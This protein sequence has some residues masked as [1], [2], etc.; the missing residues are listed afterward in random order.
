ME[1]EINKVVW[2]F[3][4]EESQQI[5]NIKGSIITSLRKW[6]LEDAYWDLRILKCECK[7]FM[8]DIEKKEI[9]RKQKELDELRNKYNSKDEQAHTIEERSEF[10]LKLEE[11]Y[12]LINGLIKSHGLCFREERTPGRI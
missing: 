7:M 1:E 12:D 9:E 2:N 6:S 5:F 10:F 3:D 4:D 11:F 8:N